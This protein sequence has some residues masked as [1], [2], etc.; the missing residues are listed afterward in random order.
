MLLE[1]LPD[2]KGRAP[3]LILAAAVGIGAV[4]RFLYLGQTFTGGDQACWAA[5]VIHLPGNKWMLGV[6]F[7][8]LGPF[9]SKGLYL[10]LLHSGVTVTEWWWHLPV[11]LAGLLQ[12][13][14]TYLLVRRWGGPRIAGAVGA[15]AAAVMPVHIFQSRYAGGH[16]VLALF[17]LSVTL[18]SFQRVMERPTWARGIVATLACA[19]YLTS[20]QYLAPFVPTVALA[21]VFLSPPAEP[22]WRAAMDGARA[23]LTRG[24]WLAP[25]ATVPV[26]AVAFRYSVSRSGP[27]VYVHQFV[28][29]ILDGFGV[30]LS[31]FTAAVLG[32]TLFFPSLRSRPVLF[33]ILAGAAWTIPLGIFAPPP[34]HTEEYALIGLYLWLLGAVLVLDRVATRAPW[35]ALV[36]GTLLVFAA[37]ERAV[38]ITFYEGSWNRYGTVTPDPGS[39]ALAVVLREQVPRWVPVLSAHS[40]LDPE[41]SQYYMDRPILWAQIADEVRGPLAYE[42]LSARAKII[43]CDRTRV[44][45]LEADPRFELL[46]TIRSWGEPQMWIYGEPWIHLSP[47]VV[48]A[49]EL[50][51]RYDELYARRYEPSAGP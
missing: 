10:F 7:G 13:P 20:H 23:L 14:L 45:V 3:V 34:I 22:W 29:P 51:R 6:T 5:S 4:L 18:V 40:R 41:V 11:A 47:A 15:L 8:A 42:T 49:E 12:V 30:L 31:L 24:V 36:I 39:K 27:G 21:L 33:C 25:L 2:W 17:C 32:T 16:E 46:M 9:L 26:L 1:V 44:P 28:H 43:V 19:V 50:N 35:V 48:E 37:A 38:W